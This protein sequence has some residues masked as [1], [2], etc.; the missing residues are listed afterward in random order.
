MLT[1]ALK[2]F[3]N[4][5]SFINKPVVGDKKIQQPFSN[6][7]RDYSLNIESRVIIMKKVKKVIVGIL[8]FGLGFGVA[9]VVIPKAASVNAEELGDIATPEVD[10]TSINN[11]EEIKEEEVNNADS[12][13]ETTNDET[14]KTS[15]STSTN[16][17]SNSNVTGSAKKNSWANGVPVSIEIVEHD[18]TE[19]TKNHIEH[20]EA[21]MAI[22][23]EDSYPTVA[24]FSKNIFGRIAVTADGK[25]ATGCS[26]EW[27]HGNFGAGA[28]SVTLKAT[29]N[30]G[31]VSRDLGFVIKSETTAITKK[32][33]PAASTSNNTCKEVE[34]TTINVV[35]AD[36][37]TK[38]FT[39]ALSCASSKA[40][41]RTVS[42]SSLPAGYS[43]SGNTLT[44]AAGSV[45]RV[46]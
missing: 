36:G 1:R 12:S 13:K 28:N 24:N 31:K 42:V 23:V 6:Y 9:G 16:K 30:E 15:G 29:C 35:M 45:Y 26:I 5:G 7:N 8:V 40:T 44:T 38:T 34:L 25:A 41:S 10:E 39:K 17:K 32:E 46:A 43:I 3:T 14:K 27:I 18:E 37:S 20:H 19:E 11:E 33:A 21:K 4:F 2:G 22:N